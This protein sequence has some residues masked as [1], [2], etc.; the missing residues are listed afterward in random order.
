MPWGLG[1]FWGLINETPVCGSPE[2]AEMKC[3]VD[4]YSV[5]NP[6]SMIGCSV[7]MFLHY[8]TCDWPLKVTIASP[9]P[10][11]EFPF[12]LP[13]CGYL[14]I[15]VAFR[16]LLMSQ[17]FLCKTWLKHTLKMWCLPLPTLFLL[18]PMCQY[19]SSPKLMVIMTT[20]HTQT[21]P[22]PAVLPCLSCLQWSQPRAVPW[23][24]CLLSSADS[25]PDPVL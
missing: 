3:A 10:R 4:T 25:N 19:P 1:D 9:P 12:L 6:G 14:A 11:H 17:D 23:Y 15:S 16:T 18:A 8:F 21:V 2:C 22:V 13:P 20:I 7:I 5:K 24:A